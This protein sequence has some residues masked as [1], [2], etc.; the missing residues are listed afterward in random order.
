MKTKILGALVFLFA[1]FLTAGTVCA[2][3]A[4]WM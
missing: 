3:D 1:M 4:D 2:G